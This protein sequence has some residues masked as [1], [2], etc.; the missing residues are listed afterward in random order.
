MALESYMNCIKFAIIGGDSNLI[1]GARF[2]G[3]PYIN[4]VDSNRRMSKSLLLKK[5][6]TKH[7]DL[8]LKYFGIPYYKELENKKVSL[9]RICDPKTNLVDYIKDL[10]N[11][12]NYHY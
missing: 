5:S 8:N 9:S 1:W 7:L 4:C 2:F 11:N 3:I 6:G 12:N 10:L